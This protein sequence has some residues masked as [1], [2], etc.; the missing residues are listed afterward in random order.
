VLAAV[1]YRQQRG[2]VRVLETMAGCG[3]RS[4]RYGLEAGADWIWSNDGNPDL[5]PLLGENLQIL[6]DRLQ[7]THDSAHKVL[8]HCALHQ[9]FYDVVDVDAFGNGAAYIPAA[10]GATRWG[11]LLY[12]T[13]TDGRTLGGHDPDQCLR[14]Y[15]SYG[16]AHPSSQEQGLRILLGTMAQ[17]AATQGWGI[18]PVLATFTGQTFRVMVRLGERSQS[19]EQTYG[20]LGYCHPCGHYE[21]VP[22]RKLGR[23][24]C[25][26]H[27]AVQP[28]TLTGPLWLGSLHDGATLGLMAQQAQA[29]G[30]LD[31]LK[32]LAI[33]IAE[34]DLPPYHFRL[35]DIGQRGAMDPP[36]RDRLIAALQGSGYRASPV[37]WNPQAIKTDAPLAHCIDIG[38][39]LTG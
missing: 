25:P 4:L 31:C 18:T 7:L 26:H 22:W 10:L 5:A 32:P 9:D 8:A 39:H 37:H 13:A 27:G 11:G 20:F 1:V 24:S 21:P 34:A 2:Q 14:R 23:A 3:V 35:G 30:W 19:L 36:P 38:Q 16:R 15:G 12:L 33:M 6:G 17:Q 28:L 29:W